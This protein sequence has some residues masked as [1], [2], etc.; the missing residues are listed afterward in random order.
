MAKLNIPRAPIFTHEGAKAQHTNPERQ[1]RRSVF[2]CMLWENTFYE[3]EESI[4]DRI[5][6]L[7]PL[8]D[9]VKVANLAIEARGRMKLRHTPLLIVRAMTNLQTHKKYV[10]ETLATVI[11]RPD[12]LS[13]FLAIY[14]KDNEG[15]KTI[16]A[17]VKK[18][19][20]K[21]FTKFTAFQLA[22]YNQDGAIKLRDVLF[23]CHAKPASPEQEEIWKQ[24][25]SNTLPTPDTWEV[26][27]SASKE[28]FFSL[29]FLVL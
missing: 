5:N 7:I 19:L 14:W 18:G 26:E 27:L 16:S 10:S 3:D 21:A 6:T 12:E 28:Q 15:K 11:Q 13:E 23:L 17:Q 29:T 2:S 8:V 4:V 24:L 20:A 9:P 25:I 1:L 22:K